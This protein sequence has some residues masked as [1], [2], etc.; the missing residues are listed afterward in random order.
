MPTELFHITALENIES[1]LRCKAVYSVS[2]SNELKLCHT[3]IAYPKIQD[4]RAKFPVPLT[5]NGFVHDYVPFYFAPRSPMLYAIHQGVVDGYSKG[6]ENIIYLVSSVESVA[7]SN[8]RYVFTDGHAIMQLSEYY[9]QLSDLNQVD[10]DIMKRQYWND[11]IDDGD[12]KR[13]RQAEFLVYEM[14]PLA[15]IHQIVVMDSRAEQIVVEK[16]CE[17]GTNIPVRV[18]RD[19]YY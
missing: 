18:T 7:A 17:V 9:N 10:W 4:R 11:T 12:R 2:K 14:L 1:I 8:L 19:W 3:S 16:T 13:R 5:P 15:N 6:Q